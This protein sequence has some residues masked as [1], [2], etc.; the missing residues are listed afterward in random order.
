M[1]EDRI[2][3]KLEIKDPKLKSQFETALRK[4]GE[5][6]DRVIGEVLRAVRPGMTEKAVARLVVDKML[7]GGVDG[8][9]YHGGSGARS[10]I[11]NCDPTGKAIEH[12][13][14]TWAIEDTRE[15]RRLHLKLNGPP[16][17]LGAFFQVR[18]MSRGSRTI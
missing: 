18:A 3:I 12:D 16:G 2:S 8:L 1:A 13:Y 17:A 5:L 7:A 15:G 4:V 6:T 9:R 11:V 10:G 14:L